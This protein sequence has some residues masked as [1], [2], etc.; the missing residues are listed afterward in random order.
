MIYSGILTY[1]EVIPFLKTPNMKKSILIL[2]NAL[3]KV[4]QKQI[5]GGALI[6]GG[7]CCNPANDCCVPND[8]AP[9]PNCP[10]PTGSPSCQFLYS[11]GACCI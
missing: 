5:T 9:R 4:E 6:K 7:G 10:S 3:N 2:G 8:G 1:L 11:S